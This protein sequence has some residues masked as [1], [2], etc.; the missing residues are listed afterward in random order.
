M[1]AWASPDYILRM[2]WRLVFL[3]L[4]FAREKLYAVKRKKF[5]NLPDIREADFELGN[6]VKV[7]R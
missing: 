6:I 2:D 1:Y 3:Y 4:D 7:K 5:E